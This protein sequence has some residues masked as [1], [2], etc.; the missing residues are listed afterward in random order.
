MRQWSWSMFFFFVCFLLKSLSP[1][2][3]A[4]TVKYIKRVITTK[5][6]G[7]RQTIFVFKNKKLINHLCFLETWRRH[8]RGWVLSVSETLWFTIIYRY[9]YI[10]INDVHSHHRMDPTDYYIII[11]HYQAI[12]FGLWPNTTKTMNINIIHIFTLILALLLLPLLQ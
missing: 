2:A 10:Y 9:I 5:T 11:A 3:S 8:L 1:C 12:F 7:R 6:T 4:Q